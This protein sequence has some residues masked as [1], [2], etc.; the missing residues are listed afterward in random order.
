MNLLTTSP[1]P[2]VL[3]P[4]LRVSGPYSYNFHVLF[5]GVSQHNKL[6][7]AD[8]LQVTAFPGNFDRVALS[9]ND[10]NKPTEVISQLQERQRVAV[11]TAF[12]LPNG[13][14]LPQLMQ[15]P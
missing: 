11:G 9:C 8:Y 7:I 4:V 3:H 12:S 13:M 15:I 2:G 14:G 6:Y 5:Y 1:S 10:L